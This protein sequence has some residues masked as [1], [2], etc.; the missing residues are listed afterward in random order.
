[1]EAPETKEI[2]RVIEIP[3][4]DLRS[5]K[6]LVLEDYELSINALVDII[7]IQ[8]K[9][10]LPTITHNITSRYRPIRPIDILTI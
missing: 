6:D 9:I 8:D 5:E 7:I 1:M 3:S 4:L 10:V 2:I